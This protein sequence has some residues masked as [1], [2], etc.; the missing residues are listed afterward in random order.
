Y[1]QSQIDPIT[2]QPY[3]LTMGSTNGMFDIQTGIGSVISAPLAGHVS[4][5]MVRTRAV[6]VTGPIT[7]AGTD[8][9]VWLNPG[10][11][12]AAGEGLV[13][14][15]GHADHGG[16]TRIAGRLEGGIINPGVLELSGS[17]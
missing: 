11:S 1:L 9:E 17:I 6:T 10:S 15:T 8:L 14:L 4:F 13:R 5:R 16:G 7:G 2:N 12:A 3:T